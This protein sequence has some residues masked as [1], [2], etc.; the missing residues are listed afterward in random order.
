[1]ALKTCKICKG[2]YYICKINLPFFRHLDFSTIDNKIILHKCN[3]CHLISNFSIPKKEYK[4]FE[5]VEYSKSNQANYS[6][7][8][9]SR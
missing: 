2:E 1:M 5:S 3:K 9:K 6:N 8:R 4:N 7:K